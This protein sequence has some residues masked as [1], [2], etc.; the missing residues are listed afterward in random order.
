LSFVP[1]A[2]G[3]IFLNKSKNQKSGY[4]PREGDRVE[5]LPKEKT[6]GEVPEATARI[7]RSA[8]AKGNIYAST[9]FSDHPEKVAW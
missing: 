9:P 1:D 6:I 8:F 2:V 5:M 3:E 4:R 7:A